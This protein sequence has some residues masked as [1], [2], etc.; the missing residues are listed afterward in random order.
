M[1]GHDIIVVGASAG[2]V[3][4]LRGI[5]AGL[6]ADLPASVF[7]VIHVAPSGPHLLP[8]ILTAAGRLP[9][10][11][12]EDK[13]EIVS[14]RIYVAPPDHHMLVRWGV[15]GVNRGPR[16]N[17]HRPAVDPL[18]RSAAVAYGPRVIGVILTGN[19][20]DGTRGLSAVKRCG[21]LAVV[22]DPNEALYPSMPA[23]ALHSTQVDHV[24]RLSDLPALLTRLARMP[25]GESMQPP[26]MV[27]V[28]SRMSGRETDEEELLDRIGTRSSLTCPE[29]HGALWGLED[30]NLL[31]FRCHVGH[32]SRPAHC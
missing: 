16:E 13:E 18:F 2:G 22:Q 4:A 8:A 19:L 12:A 25:A 1:S 17:W 21:G 29:C 30:G 20:D 7:C 5:V 26:P 6:P 32:A 14:G 9:A 10:K 3:E 23:S 11:Y 27:E 31:N 24:T 15:M 28:E